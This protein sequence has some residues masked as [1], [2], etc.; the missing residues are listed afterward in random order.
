VDRWIDSLPQHTKEYLKKQ[1][2][3]HDLDLFKAAVVGMIIGFILGLT[4]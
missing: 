4:I 1:P 2:L 3:W